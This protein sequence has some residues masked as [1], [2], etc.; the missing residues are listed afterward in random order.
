M[1]KTILVILVMMAVLAGFSQKPA[2]MHKGPRTVKSYTAAVST[3]TQTAVSSSP[4]TSASL[5]TN[6]KLHVVYGRVENGDTLIDL[7]SN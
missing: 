6:S 2:K 7:P 1:K 3:P 4:T 5:D